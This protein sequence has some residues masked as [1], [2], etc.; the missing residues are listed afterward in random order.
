MILSSI[1]R[2]WCM[3]RDTSRAFHCVLHIVLSKVMSFAKV[4]KLEGKEPLLDVVS[5]MINVM[6]V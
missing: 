2:N 3:S 5:H 1:F 6:S 4:K